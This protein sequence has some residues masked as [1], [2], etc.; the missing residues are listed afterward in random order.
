MSFL[1]SLT[2]KR[3]TLRS[4]GVESCQTP[5]ENVLEG[6][7]VKTSLRA[8]PKPVCLVGT[9][10]TQWSDLRVSLGSRTY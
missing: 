7:T 4:V 10:R 3:E 5:T 8:V 6:T 9:F 2:K 1:G